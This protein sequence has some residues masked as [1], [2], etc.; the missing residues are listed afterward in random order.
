MRYALTHLW[1]PQKNPHDPPYKDPEI[2]YAL[3]A[4]S[5]GIANEEQQL[6]SWNYFLY[7]TKAGQQF[8]DLSYRPGEMGTLATA[9]AEGSKWVGLMFLK[10]LHPALTPGTKPPPTL[11]QSLRDK[12]AKRQEPP[13]PKDHP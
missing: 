2:I 9:F 3:R 12:R 10:L 1:L 5:Q 11:R 4:W 8:Q 6:I 7:V 13:Q